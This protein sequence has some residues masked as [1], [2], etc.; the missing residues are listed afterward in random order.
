MITARN[1]V[2]FVDGLIDLFLGGA[3]LC[4]EVAADWFG[5]PLTDTAFYRT[6][7][8]GVLFGIG[9]ALVWECVRSDS[10]LV[11]LGIG[12]ERITVAKRQPAPSNRRRRS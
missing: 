8:G 7:L 4:F 3:L 6:I 5:V 1:R 2:L 11:G 10:P 12:G 9:I